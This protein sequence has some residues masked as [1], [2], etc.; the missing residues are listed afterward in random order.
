MCGICGII[1]KN[2]SEVNYDILEKMTR[3]LKH[4]GDNAWGLKILNNAGFGHQRL[5]ILDLSDKAN[6]PMSSDDK[7]YWI[8]FNGEIYNFQ[9]IKKE[10]EKYYIFKTTSDTEV[11]LYSWIH[12]GKNCLEKFNGMFAFAIWDSVE[13]KLYCIRDR[14]GVKPFFYYEGNDLFIFASEIK[15]ILLHPEVKKE[16]DIK[17]LSDYLSLGYITGEKTIFKNI[18]KLLP[19]RF[20]KLDNNGEKNIE[21]YWDI[22]GHFRKK[23]S[24]S[25]EDNIKTLLE[26]AVKLR[27]VSDV[28]IGFFLSG[29]IDS[30]AVM[31][32]AARHYN[33]PVAYS[34]GFHEESYSE[35]PY[36]EKFTNELGIKKH[37]TIFS[38]PGEDFLKKLM[39]FYD[40]PFGDTSCVPTFQLCK[41]ASEKVKVVLSGD[42]GDEMFGGY[43]TN[44]ADLMAHYGYNNIPLWKYILKMFSKCIN[45]MPADFSKVSTDYKLKQFLNYGHLPLIKAHYSWRL[46]FNDR[47]K[48]KL[49]NQDITN[50]LSEYDSFSYFDELAS[51]AEEYNPFQ[52]IIYI[53]FNTW[54]SDDILTKVDTA[55]MAHSLEIRSPFLDRY[56][57]E[58]AVSI[59]ENYKFDLF[60]TKKILKKSLSEELPD[61]IIKRKK[62]GFNSPV[63]LW[64]LNDLNELFIK[65]INNKTFKEFFPNTDY[66]KL[67][68]DEHRMKKKDRGF[69]LWALFMFGLWAE[70][71]LA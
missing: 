66:I 64:I 67:L 38:P 18:K 24:G 47:E 70:N 14:L 60:N 1:N 20:L 59:P 40:Q 23:H 50:S 7:R 68:L 10:L 27:L 54:L 26:N 3:V 42:G 21:R 12:W 44:R 51:E 34:L 71:Y 13:K 49:L 39:W 22:R 32:F 58:Y 19:G 33:N 63:A 48:E 2:G 35:L 9:S 53:D 57:I 4:R 15:S 17:G 8:V 25:I 5:S 16:I 29:G 31:K 65:T 37:I 62:E 46:L 43:E 36:V 41:F 11:V 56:V 55:G 28:D 6:Q 69:S 61:Y 52:K 30:S 45:L